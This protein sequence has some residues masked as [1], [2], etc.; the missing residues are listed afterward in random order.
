MRGVCVC[1]CVCVCEREREREREK[2]NSEIFN[3]II[4]KQNFQ[5]IECRITLTHY[6][7]ISFYVFIYLF[8]HSI[9]SNCQLYFVQKV[10]VF[11]QISLGLFQDRTMKESELILIY[12]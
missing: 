8:I 9:L 5:I 4:I 2:K 7:L 6:H 10:C 12:S 3:E 1:V 11:Y